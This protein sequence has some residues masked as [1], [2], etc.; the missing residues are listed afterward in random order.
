MDVTESAPITATQCR[1]A[2]AGLGLSLTDTAQISMVSRASIV[3][4]EN[5]SDLKP[6]LR[7]ALRLAF[8]QKGVVFS[9]DGV[10]IA[11]MD[12]TI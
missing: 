11:P 10:K 9:D 1:M 3:R 5:G 2:R 4:F 8:E 6:V 7:R 12:F